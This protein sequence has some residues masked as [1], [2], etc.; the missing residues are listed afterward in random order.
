MKDLNLLYAFEALWRDRSVTVAAERLGLTQAAV[1]S[2][3]KRMRAEY[4]DPL[5]TLVGRKMQPTPLAAELATE[6]LDALTMVRKTHAER[7]KFEPSSARRVFT[8]RTRDIGEVVCLPR[9]FAA[10]QQPAPGIRLKT[11]FKPIAETLSG[12]ANGQMDLA[13]GFLPSLESGIHRR[14]LFTQH[15]VCVMRAGHPLEQ[16][17]LTPELFSES[18]HLLVEYSGSG[19]LMLERALIDAGARHRIRMRMP[20]YMAAPHFVIQTDLLWS[21]PQVLAQRLAVHFPLVIKPHPLP[22]PEF[23]VALYWHDRYHRDPANKWLR[24]FIVSELGGNRA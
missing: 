20:Q 23:E 2:A 21:V 9:I 10:L 8:V 7:A 18:D 4:D 14:V 24:D 1:S 12:M 16:Q 13:L 19:H 5:F 15:Y 3:L 22:I 17:E 11:V 6:L